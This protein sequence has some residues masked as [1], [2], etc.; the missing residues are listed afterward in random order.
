MAEVDSLRYEH[1]GDK[2][3]EV[4]TRDGAGVLVPAYIW[5]YQMQIAPRVVG[6]ERVAGI[7]TTIV[8]LFIDHRCGPILV[9]AVGRRRGSGVPRSDAH[10]GQ[11]HGPRRRRLRRAHHHRS[12]AVNRD[13][14]SLTTLPP[15]LDGTAW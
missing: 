1:E 8:S 10:S 2:P 3:W 5:N 13:S 14:A 9:P 12:A 11:L 7:D 15:G 6:S 4:V